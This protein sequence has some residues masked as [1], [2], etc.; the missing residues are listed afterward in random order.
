MFFTRIGKVI[1]HLIL[2]MSVIQVSIAFAGAFGT[3]DMESNRA[4]ASR[5]LSAATTGEAINKAMMY[6]LLAVALGVLCEISSKRNKAD[7]QA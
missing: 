7:K 5:Y 3:A 2:W 1:A 4:F 6:L